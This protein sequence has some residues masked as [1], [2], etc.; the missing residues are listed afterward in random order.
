MCC[1]QFFHTRLYCLPCL[2]DSPLWEVL[3]HPRPQGMANYKEL[4]V[5]P[6]LKKNYHKVWKWKKGSLYL[7]HYGELA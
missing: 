1:P 2:Q 4:R 3:F 7:F 6:E 5:K